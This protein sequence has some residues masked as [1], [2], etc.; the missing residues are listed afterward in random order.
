MAN[1]QNLKKLSSRE[2]RENGKKGAEAKKQLA[3][4]RKILQ[5]LLKEGL[6]LK[7]EELPEDLRQG[8]MKAARIQD[9]SLTVG[10]ALWESMIIRACKGN[11]RMMKMI[12]DLSGMTQDAKLQAQDVKINNLM[13]K[14]QQR[15]LKDDDAGTTKN[16]KTTMEQLVE[17][18]HTAHEKRK[19]RE[20]E[21]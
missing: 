21:T 20:D 6:N 18:L 12:L 8:I 10:H 16:G 15:K 11:A 7:L 9:G 2:A 17:S 1:E 14:Q 4:R 5:A 19:E 13:I 3:A